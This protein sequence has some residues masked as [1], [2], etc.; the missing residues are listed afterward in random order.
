MDFSASIFMKLLISYKVFMSSLSAKFYPKL[1][2]IF[3]YNMALVK[4]E[5]VKQSLYRTGQTLRVPG[6]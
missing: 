5:K 3:L 4:V 6:V 1:K 2:H